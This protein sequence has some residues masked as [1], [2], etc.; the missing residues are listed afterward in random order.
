MSFTNRTTENLSSFINPTKCSNSSFNNTTTKSNS[1]FN[2][3]TKQHLIYLWS[4]EIN[5]WQLSLP[6]KFNS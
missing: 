6:W 1:S 5:P 2:N 4:K 3:N